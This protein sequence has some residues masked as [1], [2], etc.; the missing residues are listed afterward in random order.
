LNNLFRFTLFSAFLCASIAS[1]EEKFE[2]A[3]IITK[4]DKCKNIEKLKSDSR[5]IFIYKHAGEVIYYTDFVEKGK[6]VD[7]KELRKKN[8]WQYY[9]LL[10]D[11][12]PLQYE[13]GLQS[14]A[15]GEFEQAKK[16]FESSLENKTKVSK[17]LFPN[18]Y[19]SKNFLDDKMLLCAIGLNNEED[20]KKYYKKIINN[21]SAHAK[22]R[23]MV[24]YVPFLLKL[25]EGSKANSIIDECLKFDLSRS[26]K[27]KLQVMRC[28]SL[29]LQRKFSQ[30][31]SELKKVEMGLLTK[32]DMEIMPKLQE[33]HVTILVSHEKNYSEGIRFINKMMEKDVKNLNGTNYFNLAECYMNK[34]NYEEARWNYVQAY[35]YEFENESQINNIKDKILVMNQ[36]IPSEKGND[37]LNKFLKID[38]KGV[39]DT[40]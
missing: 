13:L 22:R 37:A 39:N 12:V 5:E 16:Y 14:L 29:S 19:F 7:I 9:D 17:T 33:A 3:L 21:S 25:E 23:V 10:Y 4:L 34:D 8:N 27:L 32:D 40:K 18:T 31:K 2:K 28:L 24:E 11:D 1:T 26:V 30:A 6:K 38:K 15:K 35:L 36:K 20:I